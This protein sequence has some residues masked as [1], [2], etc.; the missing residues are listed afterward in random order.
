[1]KKTKMM[2]SSIAAATII[3]LSGCAST[4]FSTQEPPIPVPIPQT[5]SFSKIK[6]RMSEKQVI[7]LL[8]E[9]TDQTEYMNWSAYIPFLDFLLP[10]AYKNFYYKN[11]GRIVL[12]ADLGLN[13]PNYIVS[14][15]L[16]DAN[17]TGYPTLN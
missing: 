4:S 2:L 7:D 17:A 8:G 11:E 15:I 13:S 5:S 3:I 14:R 12:S 9:P 16:Y 1:M 6:V 10:D